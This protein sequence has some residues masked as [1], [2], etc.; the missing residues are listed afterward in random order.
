MI[1]LTEYQHS[2]SCPRGP[3]EAELECLP[4]LFDCAPRGP[5]SDNYEYTESAGSF[6]SRTYLFKEFGVGSD[7][8]PSGPPL[9]EKGRYKLT[10]FSA[11]DCRCQ[12]LARSRR[13][14]PPSLRTQVGVRHGFLCL[15][16][17]FGWAWGHGGV[18]VIVQFGRPKNGGSDMHES[19]P[20]ATIE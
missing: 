8:G 3:T 16:H 1:A 4:N 11:Q 13:Q 7:H 5:A 14:M 6:Q 9:H 17:L 2:P 15:D 12:Y 10:V 18:Y 19:G 20:F